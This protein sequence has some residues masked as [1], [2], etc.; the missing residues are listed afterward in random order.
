MSAAGWLRRFVRRNGAGLSL[1]VLLAVGFWM[2]VL[3]V[4]PQLFMLD[5]SFRFNLPPAKVGARAP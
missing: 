4:L 5:F 3:I 1:Y 2:F